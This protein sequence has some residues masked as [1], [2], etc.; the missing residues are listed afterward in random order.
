MKIIK[1]PITFELKNNSLKNS[2][3]TLIKLVIPNRDS[4]AIDFSRLE[5]TSKGDL[6]VLIA[7]LEK[8]IITKHNKIYRRGKL[9]TGKKVKELLLSSM[10][11]VHVNKD[12]TVNKLDESEKAKLL[13]LNI[14]DSIVSGL[15]KIGIKEYFIPFNE[16]LIELIAN[17]VEHGIEN[18]NINWWLTHEIDQKNKEIKY[19]FVDMGLGIINSHK[20]AG[21][22]IKYFF[23]QNK[24]VILHAL[25]AKLGSSTKETN[26]GRG[27]PQLRLMIEKGFF[28][29]FVLISNNV[30]LHFR[31][32]QFMSSN[33]R[34]FVGTY[35]SWTID[36][37]C[38][39]QWRN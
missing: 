28:S 24:F 36:K 19:T 35:Y 12:I 26:R 4:L 37:K 6:M 39:E 23:L 38:F 29:N 14:V 21:L 7:Q 11:L 8:S 3:S 34:N 10:D 30:S 18:K 5:I 31:N 1:I 2:I 32:N 25:Y 13:N 27:L 20:K 15:K 33:N 17:A 22:P 16:F 9:P